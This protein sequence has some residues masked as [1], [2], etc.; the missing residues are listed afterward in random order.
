MLSARP[1]ALLE[2]DP[3]ITGFKVGINAG[4]SAG[5]TI[6]HVH[7]HLIP[8][9]DGDVENPRGG[10]RGVIPLKALFVR[11]PKAEYVDQDDDFETADKVIAQTNKMATQMFEAFE[12]A[13]KT[14]QAGELAP[15]YIEKYDLDQPDTVQSSGFTAKG[16]TVVL[17]DFAHKSHRFICV[18]VETSNEKPSSI[19]QIGLAF[20]SEAGEI[21]SHSL[22]IDPED[23]FLP[24]Y[25]DGRRL[26]VHFVLMLPL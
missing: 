25:L 12:E 16:Q 11:K 21:S 8:R 18:D 20:V 10:V 22:L 14:G 15:T 13:N 5:Q 24:S 17:P 6:F 26:Y 3:T 2:S 7:I 1:Q 23:N 9:R 19:C 4:Q